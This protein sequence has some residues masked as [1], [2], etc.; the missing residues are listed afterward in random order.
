MVPDADSWRLIRLNTAGL[1][2]RI[3]AP[4]HR[5][6]LRRLQPWRL[7]LWGRLAREVEGIMVLG[8][9]DD[10]RVLLVRHSYHLPDQWLLPGG[11]RASGEDMLAAAAREMAEETGC[12]LHDATHV[13]TVRRPMPQGWTNRIELVSGQISGTARADGREIVEVSLHAPDALPANAGAV[14]HDCLALW[15][16]S[17]R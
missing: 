16:A 4:L 5:W 12:M 13:G 9:A 10:G 2:A 17:E 6:V 11:G 8:F 14:V 7:W 3:P 1:I 15:Q